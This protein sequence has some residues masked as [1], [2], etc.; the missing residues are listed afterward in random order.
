MRMNSFLP[1]LGLIILAV[2]CSEEMQ[3]PVSNPGNPVVNPAPIQM[4]T[5]EL[6]L[7]YDEFNGKQIVIIGSI[8][9]TQDSSTNQTT[10]SWN[11]ATAFDRELPDGSLLD[12][13]LIQNQTPTIFQDQDGNRYDIFGHA[14]SGARKGSTLT[15][16]NAGLGFWLVFGS[17]YPGLPIHEDTNTPSVKVLEN[18]IGWGIPTNSVIRAAG[19]NS[20]PAINNPQFELFETAPGREVLPENEDRIIGLVI[21]DEVKAYPHNILDWHEIV[22]D[23]I[24]G[25]P[26]TL[27]YCPLTGTAKVWDRS[28]ISTE[29]FGVSGL[30]FNSNLIP[31]DF[32]SQSNWHQLEGRCVNGPRLNESLPIIS[33]IETTWRTWIQM[34]DETQVLTAE[35]GFSRDYSEYP[36]GDYR[37]NNDFLIGSLDFDDNRLPRKE[38]VFSIIVDGKAK[39]YT[40]ASFIN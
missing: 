1:L 28:A 15:P 8:I 5:D 31:F 37:T 30:L 27:T 29:L 36:Y 17:M 4:S 38:L 40:K 39:V 22:N 14:I 7:L 9:S 26:I 21:N 25:V 10:L 32:S 6:T 11:F 24:G 35:T 13:T 3:N 23:E 34:Y 16:I 19:V 2:A 33:H 20:I 12:L 18:A